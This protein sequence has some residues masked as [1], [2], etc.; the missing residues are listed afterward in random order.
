MKARESTALSWNQSDRRNA[1][2]LSDERVRFD[3]PCEFRRIR[4]IDP[5]TGTEFE[6]LTTDFTPPPGIVALLYRR[7]WDIEKLF[8]VFENKLNDAKAW[9]VGPIPAR[10]QSEFLV[11]LFNIALLLRTRLESH[12]GIRD[13]KAEDKY[14]AR[15]KEREIRAEANGRTISPWVKALYIR[16]TQLSCQFL[17]WLRDE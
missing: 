9:A 14:A 2:V 17:R 3:S 1:G 15:L 6:F 10:V 13:A 5:E 4:Y 16:P 7:R 12:D 8:D 11:L